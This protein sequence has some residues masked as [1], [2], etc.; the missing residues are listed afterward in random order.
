MDLSIEIELFSCHYN[1]VFVLNVVFI[2]LM[3]YCGLLAAGS[4]PP[5]PNS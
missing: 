2:C 1:S 3:F 4:V 5:V